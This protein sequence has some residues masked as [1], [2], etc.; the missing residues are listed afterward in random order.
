MKLNLVL[1]LFFITT[2]IE[3][4]DA[5]LASKM[6]PRFSAQGAKKGLANKKLWKKLGKK[7]LKYSLESGL[8][9][10]LFTA[11]L[12]EP[13]QYADLYQ[14]QCTGIKS[15]WKNRLPLMVNEEKLK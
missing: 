8:I 12:G 9:D 15:D 10:E 7:A 11:F 1:I 6:M 13:K 5:K 3:G 14:Q 4:N 2:L